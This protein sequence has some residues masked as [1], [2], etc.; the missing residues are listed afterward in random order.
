MLFQLVHN[1]SGNF[2]QEDGES[3]WI[4]Q[5]ACEKLEHLGYVIY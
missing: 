3:P 5:A 4:W 2:S 1:V